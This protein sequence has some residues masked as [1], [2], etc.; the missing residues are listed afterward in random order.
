[1]R[2]PQE[3]TF[4]SLEGEFASLDLI[5]GSRRLNKAGGLFQMN[6]ATK[7]PSRLLVGQ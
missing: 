6:S 5:Q 3:L 2:L 7:N 4:G 1:M